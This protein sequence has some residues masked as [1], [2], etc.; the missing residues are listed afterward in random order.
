M[1]SL[2]GCKW[3]R[4]LGDLENSIIAARANQPQTGNSMAEGFKLESQKSHESIEKLKTYWK[5]ELQEKPQKT[6]ENSNATRT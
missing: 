5:R 3:P 1:G 2:V 4:T 6:S